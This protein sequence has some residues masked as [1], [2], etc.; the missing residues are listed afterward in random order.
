MFFRSVITGK[1]Y[2]SVVISGEYKYLG[3]IMYFQEGM[4]KEL[5]AR[6][7]MVWKSFWALKHVYKN[8]KISIKTKIE[9]LE[10]CYCSQT[11]ALTDSQLL[12][13]LST[14]ERATER[15]I[16]NIRR[17]EVRTEENEKGNKGEGY[18]IYIVKETKM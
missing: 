14:T 13:K 7:K 10:A 11:W 6:R 17:D 9:T 8:E 16:R 3:R 4:E 18:R 12:D 1:L 2:V 15:S 5:K